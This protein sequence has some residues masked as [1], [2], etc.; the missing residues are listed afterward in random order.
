MPALVPWVA[1]NAERSIPS[2]T[3]EQFLQG[4]SADPISLWPSCARVIDS[5]APQT[6][7]GILMTR[8]MVWTKKDSG[9]V[10]TC[11]DCSWRTPVYGED[12]DW[13]G[14]EFEFHICTD[15]PP[16]RVAVDLD[17]TG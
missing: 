11:S 2:V 6:C 14:E 15:Y 16:L 12:I 4:E 10:V 9:I 7:R 13:V 17:K 1:R 5:P 3:S 8:A